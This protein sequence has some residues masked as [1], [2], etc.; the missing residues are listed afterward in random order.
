MFLD[1][2]KF[3]DKVDTLDFNDYKFG[4]VEDGNRRESQQRNL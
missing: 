2:Y 1:I 3:D 4:F